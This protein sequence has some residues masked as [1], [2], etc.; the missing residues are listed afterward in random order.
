MAKQQNI[1]SPET[2]SR[3]D[4]DH[5]RVR[6]RAALDQLGGQ[7]SSRIE[8]MPLVALAGGLALGALIASV[9]PQTERESELLEPVGTKVTD[10]GRASLD[11]V[12]E[13]GKAKV[14]ELAGDRLREFFGFGGSGST[15]AA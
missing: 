14:D 8:S 2:G 5:L 3:F 12:R 6:G 4:P 9:L 10:A 1:D 13:A 15:E 7:A 11:K